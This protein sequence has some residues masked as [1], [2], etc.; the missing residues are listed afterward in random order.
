MVVVWVKGNTVV[1]VP[2][3][4]D[5]LL[6][7]AGYGTCLMEWAVR[8]V[9]FAFGM[10]IE[11]LEI[12]CLSGFAIFLAQI[13]MRWHQIT[14]SPTG[15]GSRTPNE[16]SWSRPACTSL[17]Q[18]SGTGMGVSYFH[19]KNWAFETPLPLGIS[20]N[21]PWDGHGYFL[22]LHIALHVT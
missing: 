16:T 22:E 20:I 7:A 11:C 1:A 5:S 19:S 6:S 2:T 18:W 10:E 12:H 13:T 8:V 17:C 21:L 4:K 3:V 14:G 15:T 9:S